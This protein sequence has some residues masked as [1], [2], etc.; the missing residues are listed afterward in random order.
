MV[1]GCLDLVF[2]LLRDITM[3]SGRKGGP[4][5]FLELHRLDSSITWADEVDKLHEV[6]PGLRMREA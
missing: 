1:S 4:R 2:R 5:S 6:Q 3:T